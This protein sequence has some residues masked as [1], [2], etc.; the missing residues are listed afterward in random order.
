[1]APQSPNQTTPSKPA[2]PPTSFLTLPREI[3]QIILI[4]AKNYK[5]I[6]PVFGMAAHAD[7]EALTLMLE[8][9]RNKNQQRTE[10]EH[11]NFSSMHPN[12]EAD[13]EYVVERWEAMSTVEEDIAA[14]EKEMM[15][16]YR[17]WLHPLVGDEEKLIEV[18]TKEEYLR[19]LLRRFY[20]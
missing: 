9:Y 5:T 2:K 20:F 13:M 10:E 12:I 1:M 8:E 6:L 4:L 11:R 14:L 15:P 3:R 16:G 17:I 7:P 18:E 19:V